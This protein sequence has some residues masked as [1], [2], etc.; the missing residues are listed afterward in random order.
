MQSNPETRFAPIL[1][2]A[3][4]AS[5]PDA[6]FDSAT[7]YVPMRPDR[8]GRAVGRAWIAKVAQART[9]WG[10]TCVSDR[11]LRR[12]ERLDPFGLRLAGDLAVHGLLTPDVPLYG[13]MTAAQRERAADRHLHRLLRT[14]DRAPRKGF[15]VLP[16]LKAL[17]VDALDVQLDLAQELGLRRVAFYAREYLLERDGSLLRRF[18][19]GAHRRRLEPLLL[20]AQS[21]ALLAWGPVHLAAHHPYVLARRGV[22]L[23]GRGR[24]RALDASRYSAVARRFLVPGDRRTLGTHNHLIVRQRIER[25][26]PNALEV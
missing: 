6:P 15:D 9:V 17:D 20:G 23:D 25:A 13:F 10:H 4:P 16:L 3:D 14:I 11:T 24:R 18:V 5:L 2:P 12:L 21:P 7:V 19:R 1:E 8:R 22:F 26:M